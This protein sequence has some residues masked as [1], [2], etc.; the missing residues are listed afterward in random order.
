MKGD[1]DE[2]IAQE[3]DVDYLNGM[4]DDEKDEEAVE[5]STDPIESVAAF[6]TMIIGVLTDNELD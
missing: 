5:D 1:S 4:E 3:E 2:E 6:K